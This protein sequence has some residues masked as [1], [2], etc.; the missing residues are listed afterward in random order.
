MFTFYVGAGMG[1]G[2]APVSLAR[3]GPGKRACRYDARGR[4]GSG[5]DC[6]WWYRTQGKVGKIRNDWGGVRQVNRYIIFLSWGFIDF[7]GVFREFY[8]GFCQWVDLA[9]RKS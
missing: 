3:T 4:Q 1:A 8:D 2:E 5:A 9:V 7:F 6:S